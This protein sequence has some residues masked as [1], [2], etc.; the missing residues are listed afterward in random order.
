MHYT[1]VIQPLDKADEALR[2]V[3]IRL[4]TGKDHEY[5]MLPIGAAPVKR[6]VAMEACYGTEVFRSLLGALP[7]LRANYA[8][9]LGN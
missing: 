2:C 6:S 1:D 9:L 3:L 4:G 7:N 8:Q 5:T